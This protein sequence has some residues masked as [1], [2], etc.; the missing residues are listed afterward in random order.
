MHDLSPGAERPNPDPPPHDPR[1]A[2]ILTFDAEVSLFKIDLLKLGTIE[3]KRRSA[4][5]SMT[6]EERVVYEIILAEPRAARVLSDAHQAYSDHFDAQVRK[7]AGTIERER[8]TFTNGRHAVHRT[9]E[10]YPSP[11]EARRTSPSRVHARA[12]EHRPAGARRTA[13][14]STTASADPG[15]SSDESEPPS[16]GRRCVACGA[17]ISHRRRDALTC[18][19]TAC[20]KAK[21]RGKVAPAPRIVD[22]DRPSKAIEDDIAV[23][24]WQLHLAWQPDVH[25][26]IRRELT[27]KL[28]E[29]YAE[30]RYARARKPLAAYYGRTSGEFAQRP[31]RSV[32]ST[33]GRWPTTHRTRHSIP[34]GQ[35]GVAA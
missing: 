3:E 7:H 6:T 4:P 23:T 9:V 1:L 11:R 10:R 27:G 30:L 31:K 14:S 5:D 29:L 8:H 18:E 35:L 15:S 22:F 24:A 12:R 33:P 17:D 2:P 19:G 32:A 16:P 26:D 28:I 21:S 20:R 25:R 34:A 13:S